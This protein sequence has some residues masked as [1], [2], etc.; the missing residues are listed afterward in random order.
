M[1]QKKPF[2]QAVPQSSQAIAFDHAEFMRTISQE[3]SRT[4]HVIAVN[5]LAAK[6]AS[7]LLRGPLATHFL[8][9][10]R[11]GEWQTPDKSTIDWTEIARGAF[12]LA[13]KI[14]DSQERRAVAVLAEIQQ[15]QSL[16]KDDGK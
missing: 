1:N 16:P 10:A 13:E 4:A 8:Y 6:L 2:D 11:S 5:A 12:V 15:Q 9:R 7:D 14:V 3:M